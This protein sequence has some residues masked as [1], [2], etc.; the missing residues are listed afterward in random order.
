MNRTIKT[1]LGLLLLIAVLAWFF[2][3]RNKSVTPT[4]QTSEQNQTQELVKQEPDTQG[5]E[6]VSN[7]ASR[8]TK[9]P[10]GT[11]ITPLTSPVQPERFHGYHTGTDFETTIA[12]ASIEV[13]FYAICS[14]KVQSKKTA[15]GYGGV[16]VQSCAI[17]DQAVTVIYGHVSLDSIGKNVG[18]DITAGEKIGNLGQ[19]PADTDGER[20]HLHL[21]IHKGTTINILGYT[22]NQS[23]LADWFDWQKIN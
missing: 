8:I 11:Y 23:A 6:P 2:Y 16:L 17:N 18:D 3:P 10:F 14:G 12:E 9:K 5:T 19:P 22:Q 4:T 1:I 7:A 15:T 13:P 20:K 21:G